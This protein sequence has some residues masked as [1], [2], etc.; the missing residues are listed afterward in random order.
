MRYGEKN[1]CKL[2]SFNF[3]DN[4]YLRLVKFGKFTRNKTF[5]TVKHFKPSNLFKNNHLKA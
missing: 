5:Q 4:M 1:G 3:F 2:V